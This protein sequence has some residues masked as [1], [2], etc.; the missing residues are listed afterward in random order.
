MEGHSISVIFESLSP[1]LLIELGLE[2]NSALKKCYSVWK[3]DLGS[4][5][6]RPMN[7]KGRHLIGPKGN[8]L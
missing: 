1:Q 4:L 2:K 7:G 5:H 6:A 8:V 3:T